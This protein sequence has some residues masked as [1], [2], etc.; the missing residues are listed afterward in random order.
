MKK[1]I[2]EIKKN[3]NFSFGV[4]VAGGLCAE[5]LHILKDLVRRYP[6]I[7]IDA[8]TKLRNSAGLNL[9]ACRSYLTVAAQELYLQ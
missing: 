8:E 9:D 5:N 4:G 6:S 1:Y 7:S 3:N 2:L